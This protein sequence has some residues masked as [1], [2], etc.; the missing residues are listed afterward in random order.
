MTQPQPKQFI[1]PEVYFMTHSPLT[2]F[3]KEHYTTYDEARK[4]VEEDRLRCEQ[5]GSSPISTLL[6]MLAIT[7][8]ELLEN[9]SKTIGSQNEWSMIRWL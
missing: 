6:P 9:S 8:T 7:I 2:G 4:I 5:K 1:N 3:S